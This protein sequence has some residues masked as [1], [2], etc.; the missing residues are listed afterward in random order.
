M[1]G[2]QGLIRQQNERCTPLLAA[3][4]Y[5]PALL[6]STAA[7]TEFDIHSKSIS[8]VDKAKASGPLPPPAR[9]YNLTLPIRIP[10]ITRSLMLTFARVV[11]EFSRRR[12]YGKK[13]QSLGYTMYQ[14]AWPATSSIC[15]CDVIC[16]WNVRLYST[17]RLF[18]VYVR[19]YIQLVYI[20]T[21]TQG[22]AY[23]WLLVWNNTVMVKVVCFSHGDF[24][25][26]SIL[27]H[28]ERSNMQFQ[29]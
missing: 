7:S 18:R 10:L 13:T 26:K 8:R 28:A 21:N 6:P 5:D 14:E 22:A 29:K 2:T 1:R 9:P 17:R 4:R 20:N 19:L 3:A 24:E 25:K 12:E 11:I 23:Y 27:S 15:R 16:L